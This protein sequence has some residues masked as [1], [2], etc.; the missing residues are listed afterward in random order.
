LALLRFA[1]SSR[2]DEAERYDGFNAVRAAGSGGCFGV[3]PFPFDLDVDG[4]G[5]DS[6]AVAAMPFVVMSMKPFDEDCTP[7]YWR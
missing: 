2:G 5:L 3:V 6:E 4:D 7:R 1:R